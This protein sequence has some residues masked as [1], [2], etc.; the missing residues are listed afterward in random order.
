L[1]LS[2][3][4]DTFKKFAIE[5][6]VNEDEFNSCLDSG[7]YIEEINKDLKDGTNY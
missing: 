4:I 5:L 3:S 1:E 6:G 7:K 2:D